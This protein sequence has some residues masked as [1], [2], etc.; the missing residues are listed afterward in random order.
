MCVSAVN[1]MLF[2]KSLHVDH[3]AL[4]KLS[5]GILNRK[6]TRHT[7]LHIKSLKVVPQNSLE[8]Q[9]ACNVFLYTKTNIS[10]NKI[11]TIA[12]DNILARRDGY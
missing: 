2:A 10:L 3:V 6:L 7:V 12:N 11:S 4:R 9:S 8:R 5:A 1:Q